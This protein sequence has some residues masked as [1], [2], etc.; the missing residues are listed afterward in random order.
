M[1]HVPSTYGD[2]E[3]DIEAEETMPA[4]TTKRSRNTDTPKGKG[5]QNVKKTTSGPQ[6]TMKQISLK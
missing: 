6:K 3:E 1:H 5:K 2:Y 4:K